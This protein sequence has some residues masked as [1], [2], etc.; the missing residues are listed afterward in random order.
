MAMMSVAPDC[1][2][3]PAPSISKRSELAETNMRKV[4]GNRLAGAFLDRAFPTIGTP[5]VEWVGPAE[6]LELFFAQMPQFAKLAEV[7]GA[8]WVPEAVAE[9]DRL[10]ERM[11]SAGDPNASFSMSGPAITEFWRRWQY[12]IIG[13]A[14][15]E[16]AEK[17]LRFP[18]PRL[19]PDEVKGAALMLAVLGGPARDYPKHLFDRRG[20]RAR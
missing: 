3:N 16:K 18:L 13:L 7:D 4:D 11:S 8:D 12:A 10:L 2:N 14:L 1:W 15:E 9:V 6:A 20:G 17:P 5:N 19:A